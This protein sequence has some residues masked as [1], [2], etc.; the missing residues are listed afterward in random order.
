MYEYRVMGA[1]GIPGIEEEC[2]KRAKEGWELV[3]AF[4]GEGGGLLKGERF[5]LI[6]RR[7]KAT[8]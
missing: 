1:R 4:S 3:E 5:I 8:S 7:P 2:N 6:F